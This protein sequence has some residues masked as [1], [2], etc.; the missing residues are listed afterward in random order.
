MPKPTNF[1][2]TFPCNRLNSIEQLELRQN[3]HNQKEN[4]SMPVVELNELKAILRP[5]Q[6]LLGLD[7]G[8][9]TIGLA[10]SD[11]MR[12]IATPMETIRRSKFTLDAQRLIEIVEQHDIGGLVLGLPLSM[13]GSEGPRCQSTR[14]FASNLLKKTDVSITLWDER[15]SSAAVER[16]LIGEVDMTRKRRREVVDKAAAAYILQGALNALMYENRS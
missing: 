16:V 5:N 15:L 8:S 9:K 11:V 1:P 4:N 2:T 13:D 6:R 14:T 12:S 7:L 10:L 3:N